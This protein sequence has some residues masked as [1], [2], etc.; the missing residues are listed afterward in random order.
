MKIF[1]SQPMRNKTNV[2][3]FKERDKI[4]NELQKQFGLDTEFLFSIKHLDVENNINNIPVYHLSKAI[5]L[6][7]KADLAY[8]AK[9][10]TNARGCLIEHQICNDYNINI[11]FEAL[12]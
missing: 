12:K 3:I 1:I 11:I 2:E 7:S 6:L 10:W 5:E 9:G 8:F 4:M